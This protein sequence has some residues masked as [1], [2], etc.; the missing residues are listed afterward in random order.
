MFVSKKGN[1][2]YNVYLSGSLVLLTILL[3]IVLSIAII[4]YAYKV[5]ETSSILYFAA[6]N[7]IAIMLISVILA[8]GLGFLL[9]TLSKIELAKEKTHTKSMFEVIKMFMSNDEKKTIDFLVNNAGSGTQAEISKIQGMDRVKAH[10]VIKSLSEK[11]LI[12]V[13]LY[14]KARKVTIKSHVFDILKK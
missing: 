1:V 2:R 4:T 12:D 5:P 8:I 7:H 10:R 9:A 3:I 6:Q 11:K 13:N 14:G